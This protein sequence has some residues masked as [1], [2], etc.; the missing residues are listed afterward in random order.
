MLG[1]LVVGDVV[2][3]E[4]PYDKAITNSANSSE[5]LTL[6]VRPLWRAPLQSSDSRP[7]VAQIKKG[8]GSTCLPWPAPVLRLK[9]SSCL[10]QTSPT[11]M[12]LNHLLPPHPLFPNPPPLFFSPVFFIS[13]SIVVWSSVVVRAADV[14]LYSFFF[15]MSPVSFL[16]RLVYLLS[17]LVR[18]TQR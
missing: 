1:G 9:P 7:W 13:S 18:S 2:T 10:R 4:R 12:T 11:D 16:T 17:F 8:R 5:L 14:L 15:L 6:Y 3:Q